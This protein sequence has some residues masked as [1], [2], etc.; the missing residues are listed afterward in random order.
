MWNEIKKNGIVAHVTDEKGRGVY[1]IPDGMASLTAERFINMMKWIH[2]EFMAD[3]TKNPDI[4]HLSDLE[5]Q[6]FIVRN[7]SRTLSYINHV[8]SLELILV[9]LYKETIEK[10]RIIDNNISSDDVGL[11]V[12]KAEIADCFTFRN[13]VSAHTAYG[14]PRDEDNI[15]MEF[16]SL[17]TL[18]ST[19]YGPDGEAGGFALGAVSVRLA[20]QDPSTKLPL[21]GLKDLHPRMLEHIKAWEAMLISPCVVV[22]QGLPTTIGATRYSVE[23]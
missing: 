15:A 6:V 3:S 21:I 17:I 5:Q 11:E 20:E 18:L 7:M 4:F 16:Q 14:S 13:K 23:E 10:L 12:R 19:S 22:R 9:R 1:T 2:E 8:C